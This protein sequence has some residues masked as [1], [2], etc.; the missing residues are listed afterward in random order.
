MIRGWRFWQPWWLVEWRGVGPP[1]AERWRTAKVAHYLGTLPPRCV[2]Q[3]TAQGYV[4]LSRDLS[5]PD[6]IFDGPFPRKES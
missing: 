6:V 1:H 4:V 5:Y 3:T 2:L